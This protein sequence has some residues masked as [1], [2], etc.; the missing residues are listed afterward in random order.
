MLTYADVC[1]RMLA[2]AG[3]CWRMTAYV[4]QVT[5]QVSF[6]FLLRQYLYFCTSKVPVSSFVGVGV[7]QR[8]FLYFC[9]CKASKLSVSS[10]QKVINEA[11]NKADVYCRMLTYAAAR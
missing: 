6:F 8:Q 5:E 7:A 10:V 11:R 2:Y 3:V 4:R 9:T 1:W